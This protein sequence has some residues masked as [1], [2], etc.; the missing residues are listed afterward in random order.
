MIN[1]IE[2]HIVD[3]CNLGCKGCSH[4]SG[5]SPE[6]FKNLAE[7]E[8]DMKRLS[9][10]EE[11]QIIRIMGGEPLLHPNFADFCMVAREYFPKADVVL[12]TN[13]LLIHRIVPYIDEFN[14][15][16]IAV[17][18][19]DYGLRAGLDSVRKLNRLY[20]HNKGQ[21]YNI[22]LDLSGNQNPVRSFNY[23][24]LAR[25]HW[26]FLKDGRLYT[27]CV[28]AN[29][30]IFIEHFKVNMPYALDDVSIDIYTH[31]AQEI[32][33][34]LRT[35]HDACCYCDTLRRKQSY[36]QFERSK[37]DIREWLKV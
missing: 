31:N 24:D 26:Y 15:A 33:S 37:G 36:G 14:E 19:S 13:G 30:D 32:E 21:M 12:V 29:I 8:L 17:C 18:M 3:H 28:M 6:R 25:N 11:V 34:F 10:I 16:G 22:S 4:F 27:C 7:F 5:L 35:P 20:G 9:A 23:C 1:Y 2:T